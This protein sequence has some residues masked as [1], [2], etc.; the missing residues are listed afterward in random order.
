MSTHGNSELNHENSSKRYE[1]YRNL[2]RKL[3]FGVIVP[4][5]SWRTS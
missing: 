3:L 5:I 1:I 2:R 4:I